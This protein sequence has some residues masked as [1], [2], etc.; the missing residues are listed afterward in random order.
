[1]EEEANRRANLRAKDVS[2]RKKKKKK[3]DM[4]WNEIIRNIR[5]RAVLNFHSIPNHHGVKPG[6][7][8]ADLYP[9]I[10]EVSDTDLLRH[11]RME[12]P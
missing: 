11:I 3:G 9:T 4:D 6:P 5:I 12:G 2:V 10:T 7:D 8:R 1:M